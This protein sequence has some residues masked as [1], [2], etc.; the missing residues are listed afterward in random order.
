MI[1]ESIRKCIDIKVKWVMALELAHVSYK[2]RRNSVPA[3]SPKDT[4]QVVTEIPLDG[5]E[6][7]VLVV[8]ISIQ[9]GKCR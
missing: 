4:I 1:L 2:M 7:N 6:S 9:D 8:P 3:Q 5:P